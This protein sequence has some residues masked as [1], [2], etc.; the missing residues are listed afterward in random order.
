MG[1]KECL[2]FMQFVDSLKYTINYIGK[3]ERCSKIQY[4]PREGV[5]AGPRDRGRGSEGP[6]ARD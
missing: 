1:L 6:R 3:Q 2:L 5:H 4:R